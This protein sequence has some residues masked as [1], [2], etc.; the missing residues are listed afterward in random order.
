MATK[1]IKTRN[2]AQ[3][4]GSRS[5]KNSKAITVILD[6]EPDDS[7]VS[8]AIGFHD[9]HPANDVP[10]MQE[11]LLKWYDQVKRDLPWRKINQIGRSDVKVQNEMSDNERAYA[12]WVSEI[13]LQQT[14]VATVIDYYNRWMKKWPTVQA[15]A[16]AKLEEVNEMWTGLGYYSRGR[17]LH[18]GAQKVVEKL[19]GQMP[20]TAEDLQ[21]ELP[22]VGRYTAGAIAS[23]AFG[24]KT[25]VVDGNVIRVLSRLRMIGA[26]ST[27]PATMEKFWNLANGLTAQCDRPGDFN[28]AMMELGATVCMPK[29]PKCSE[30]P[31]HSL[32]KAY[33]KV[34][35]DKQK[36]R[37][38]L[39]VAKTE[40]HQLLDIECLADGC[41]WC[42]PSDDPWDTSLGVLNHPRKAKKK[43]PRDQTSIVTVVCKQ[44]TDNQRQFL[45]FQRPEK[46][47]LAGLWEFPSWDIDVNGNTPSAEASGDTVNHLKYNHKVELS[48]VFNKVDLGEVVHLFSHINQTYL[49]TLITVTEENITIL[50]ERPSRW[51]TE[52]ELGEAAIPTAMKKV[53]K[54]CSAS[55]E[56]KKSVQNANKRKREAS[57]EDKRKQRSI[58]SFFSP[59]R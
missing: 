6:D 10:Q 33:Q 55:L 9:F 50:S 7:Q 56:G 44:C 54:L 45:L 43:P 42:L 12:V 53:F 23:I 46:G 57:A 48:G 21:K 28:Q 35:S 59:K 31:V 52:E 58:D 14:Q 24:Q 29:T 37:G 36:E 47:L 19:S 38:R 41:K 22:G 11:K 25:G 49:V 4:T 1:K 15:L 2:T 40:K 18:E 3:R 34:E 32:C 30:C 27:N 51:L 16:S 8:H 26:D 5:S 39:G 20:R 13:M 17:R